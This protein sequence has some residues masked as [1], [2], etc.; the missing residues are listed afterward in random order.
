MG[1][2]RCSSFSAKLQGTGFSNGGDINLDFLQS[3]R[4]LCSFSNNDTLAQLD[5]LKPATF[6]NRYYINL[7]S[8]EGL[9]PSS[10]VLVTGDDQTRGIVEAYVEN[11]FAFFEDFKY[12]MVRMGSLGPLTGNNGVIHWNCRIVNWPPSFAKPA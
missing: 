3:L 2:A 11:Q 9:L 8:R 6:D 12:V 7:L 5:L 10:Q 4:Q 1:K